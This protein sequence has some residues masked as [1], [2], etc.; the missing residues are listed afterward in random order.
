MNL[1]LRLVLKNI[2]E[3][4]EYVKENSFFIF[5]FENKKKIKYN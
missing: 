2:K 4:K 3:R 1:W 5:D